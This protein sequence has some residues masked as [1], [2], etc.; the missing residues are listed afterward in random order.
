MK[1]AKQ[2]RNEFNERL[3]WSWEKCEFYIF[4]SMSAKDFHILISPS[5]FWDVNHHL[6]VCL[7]SLG[8][9]YYYYI[10]LYIFLIYIIIYYYILLYIIIYIIILYILLYIII[11]YE[12]YI[13]YIY[14]IIIYY[15]LYIIYIYYYYIYIILL[16]IY[17]LYIILLYI[18]LIYIIILYIYY[19]YNYLYVS[20]S[21]LDK[22]R[23]KC[24]ICWNES[25]LRTPTPTQKSSTSPNMGEVSAAYF[26]IT[27]LR[28]WPGGLSISCLLP[29]CLHPCLPL[30]DL[31]GTIVFSNL[32]HCHHLI[33]RCQTNP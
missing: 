21:V 12:L 16:Y 19:I 20:V 5:W 32:V 25:W 4:V 27:S 26:V 28:C 3:W 29:T 9:H 11:L 10:L 33:P 30:G 31:M 23:R 18:Y 1:P 15:Y 2:A 7:G 22:I 17:L 8:Y 6:I 24:D 14:Y 13:W